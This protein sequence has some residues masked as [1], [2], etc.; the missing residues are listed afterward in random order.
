MSSNNKTDILIKNI[1]ELRK[2]KIGE[3]TIGQLN[4]N[5]IGLPSSKTN[6]DTGWING[7]TVE[8]VSLNSTFISTSANMLTENE[9]NN[10]HF[11]NKVS[12]NTISKYNELEAEV[13]SNKFNQSITKIQLGDA[14]VDR[15]RVLR[16]NHILM[17][18]IVMKYIM[19][20]LLENKV[21]ENKEHARLE[22]H[23][24]FNQED[25]MKDFESFFYWKWVNQQHQMRDYFTQ[26]YHLH[27]KYLYAKRPLP[28]SS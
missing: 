3:V 8:L 11:G 23:Y 17:M 21:V 20:I 5:I 27:Q 15:W 7:D 16:E 26:I 14:C 9:T 13:D 12:A 25:I 4:A 10:V 18:K 1:T 2:G 22:M 19:A 28:T 6:G 24:D